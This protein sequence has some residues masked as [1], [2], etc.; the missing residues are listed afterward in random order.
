MSCEARTERIWSRDTRLFHRIPPVSLLGSPPS[1]HPGLLLQAARWVGGG[2]ARWLFLL[3][4]SRHSGVK[5][6]KVLKH[7]DLRPTS[8]GSGKGK[9]KLS[10]VASQDPGCSRTLSQLEALTGVLPERADADPGG[11]MLPREH[12]GHQGAWATPKQHLTSPPGNGAA[13][14]LPSCHHQTPTLS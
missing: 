11:P 5:G 4:H 13:A 3:K 8:R 6:P 12:R 7:H 2:L 10:A 1:L 9:R 14:G